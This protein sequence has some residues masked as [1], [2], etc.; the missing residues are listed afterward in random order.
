MQS[1]LKTEDEYS[2]VSSDLPLI[3]NLNI[4]ENISLIKEVHEF[5]PSV[6]AQSVA[7]KLLAEVN[8]TQIELYRENQCSVIEIFY[9]MFI[10]ALMCREKNIFIEVKHTLVENIKDSESLFKN[11]NLLKKDKNIFILDLVANEDY[12]KGSLCNI[13]K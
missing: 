4:L 11:I 9:V 2:L 13:I 3:Y 8:L 5:M 1:F 7:S 12:Y 6:E 10:R